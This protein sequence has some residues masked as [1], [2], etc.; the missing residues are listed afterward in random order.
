MLN[1][2]APEMIVI[3]VLALL[4]FGPNRLPEIARSMGKFIRNFQSE[5]NRAI[6]D[7]K[8]GIEPSTT[9]IF[10]EPDAITAAPPASPVSA[11]LAT[12]APAKH[13][14]TAARKKP[15]AKKQASAKKKAP[16]RK[17]APVQKKAAARRRPRSK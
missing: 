3:L 13:R 9:G 14:V 2:G 17:A 10:D 5:T 16:T 8:R 6:G 7:L 4:V 12:A 1:I 15:A 11:P